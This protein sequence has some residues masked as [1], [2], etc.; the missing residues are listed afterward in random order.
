VLKRVF[1]KKLLLNFSKRIF[2]NSMR[3]EMVR[4]V[5]F[6][7]S[8]FLRFTPAIPLFFGWRAGSGVRRDSIWKKKVKLGAPN[9]IV[10]GHGRTESATQLMVKCNATCVETVA[11]GFPDE[12]RCFSL[13]PP[14]FCS[15]NR[16]EVIGDG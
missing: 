4:G 16:H 2:T 10:N 11:T 3:I 6:G 9:A 1:V 14:F 13:S 8:T 12:A 15:V 7:P 5:G